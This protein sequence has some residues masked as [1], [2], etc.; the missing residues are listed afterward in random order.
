MKKKRT[1][2]NSAA[3][4]TEALDCDSFYSAS[5]VHKR[6]RSKLERKGA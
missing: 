4:R 2:R 3:T 6:H 5:D 1:P